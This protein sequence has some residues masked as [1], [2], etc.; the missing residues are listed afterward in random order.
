MLDTG[1]SEAVYHR[2]QV[3]GQ[4][5]VKY[6]RRWI[7]DLEQDPRARH[8]LAADLLGSDYVEDDRAKPWPG[9]PRV[10]LPGTLL[11]ARYELALAA[12][13]R[14]R[15]SGAPSA[16]PDWLEASEAVKD[17]EHLQRDRVRPA[18]A[19]SRIAL[20]RAHLDIVAGDLEGAKPHIAR[21]LR[22]RPTPRERF[23]LHLAHGDALA[24]AG[25]DAVAAYTDALHDAARL[26]E[27]DAHRRSVLKRLAE[28]YRE[29]DRLTEAVATLDGLDPGDSDREV[30]LIR[31]TIAL[32]CG[33]AHVAVRRTRELLAGDDLWAARARLLA[34]RRTAPAR[35]R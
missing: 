4:P 29:R 13:H 34:A 10:A 30:A 12:I 17:V 21:A 2:F 15:I 32:L 20:A 33:E 3:E 27:A 23:W 16:H 1:A 6:W 14:A 26:P 31:A 25:H 28:H 24:H 7:D 18:V 9:G 11:R 8:V 19:A 22:G 35:R 5:A